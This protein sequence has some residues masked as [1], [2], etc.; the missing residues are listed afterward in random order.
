M[1]PSFLALLVLAGC[2]TSTPSPS[3]TPPPAAT[4]E[5]RT[6]AGTVAAVDLDPMAYDA[7][8]VVTVQTDGGEVRVL[9]PARYGLCAATYDDWSGLAVGDQVEVRGAVDT[10]GAVRPCESAEHYFR[11]R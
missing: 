2:V 6:I 5:D 4:G 11:I 3:S 7:D 8:G 1:R 9:L 10:R